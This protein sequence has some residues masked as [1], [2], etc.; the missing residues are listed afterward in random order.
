MHTVNVLWKAPADFDAD[1]MMMQGARIL[2]EVETHFP[3]FHTRQM[4][5]EFR[6]NSKKWEL[7]SPHM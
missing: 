2:K 3:V 7:L 1:E 4:K 5:R 6:E